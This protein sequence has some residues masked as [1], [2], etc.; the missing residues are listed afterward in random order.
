MTKKG[1]IILSF[2]MAIL[3]FCFVCNYLYAT[4]LVHHVANMKRTIKKSRYVP[5]TS[6]ELRLLQISARSILEH[7]FA[8]ASRDASSVGYKLSIFTHSNGLS[9]YILE[10]RD[11]KEKPWGT[12]IFYPESDAYDYAIEI[13]HPSTINTAL[14]GIRTF[15][16]SKSIAFLMAGTH[17]GSC[18][19]TIQ[20]GTA[21]QAIHEEINRYMNASIQILGVDNSKYPDVVL[22]SGSTLTNASMNGLIDEIM[23]QDLTV[24]VYDGISYAEVGALDNIQGLYVNNLGRD[25]VAIFVNKKALVSNKRSSK[26]F[27]AITEYI[28]PTADSSSSDTST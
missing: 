25:F 10:A 15:I 22:S 17:P 23:Y 19:V 5:P 2:S 26:L 20:P 24:E 21:F 28:N 13:P 18:D 14:L 3:L 7:N 9:Y 12:Y 6:G 4:D 16:A 11:S 1:K 8:R 27:T